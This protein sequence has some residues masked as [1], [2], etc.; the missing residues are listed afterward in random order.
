MEPLEQSTAGLVCVCVKERE[1][2]FLCGI[3][4]AGALDS[5]RG[6]VLDCLLLPAGLGLL[7]SSGCACVCVFVLTKSM[8]YMSVYKFT[9]RQRKH[10]TLLLL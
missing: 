6:I 7:C 9:G 10:T 4:G 5:T 8:L 2:V 3:V 1:S